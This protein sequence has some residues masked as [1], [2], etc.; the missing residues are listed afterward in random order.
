MRTH[1]ETITCDRCGAMLGTSD[2][3]PTLEG[4]RF[5]EDGPPLQRLKVAIELCPDCE[6][7]LEAWFKPGS[8]KAKKARHA[9]ASG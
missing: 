6:K 9:E 5:V 3:A 7:S 2:A 4:V 1:T 8:K